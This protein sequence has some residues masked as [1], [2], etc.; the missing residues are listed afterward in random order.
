LSS[1]VRFRAEGGSYAVALDAVRLV[2]TASG[3]SPLP[4]ARPGVAGL[5][6]QAGDAL[7]VL[8]VLGAGDYVLVLEAEGRRFGLLVH[9]VA[10][11]SDVDE[12]RLR[13]APPGQDEAIVSGVLEAGSEL[14][15]LV[16]AAALARW[17][18][19]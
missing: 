2:R 5:V 11:V 1:V 12:G 10:G 19:G 3:L 7:P 13:P 18:L 14:V 9:D 6:E 8:S 4:S 15:L 17:A 16:D